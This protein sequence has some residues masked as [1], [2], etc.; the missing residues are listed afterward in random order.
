[1]AE[2]ISGSLILNAISNYPKVSVI[3]LTC[4]GRRYINGLLSSLYDQTYPPDR[5]EIIVIDNGSVDDTV[6]R[7]KEDFP[8]VKLVELGKNLGFARGNNEAL[9]HAGGE[10]LVFMNQD[11]VCHREWIDGLMRGWAEEGRETG[12]TVSNMIL[13]DPAEAESLDRSKRFDEIFYFDLSVFGYGYYRRRKERDV[14]A[15]IFS[16]CSFGIRRDMIEACGGYLFDETFD[17]YAEDTE[18]SLRLFNAGY[19]IRVLRDSVVYHLHSSHKG[20]NSVRAGIAA[21][22]IINRVCAFYKNMSFMEFV[23][24]YPVLIFCGVLKVPHLRVSAWEK[25]LWFLP[26]GLFSPICMLAGIPKLV[27]YRLERKRILAGRKGGPFSL[28]GFIFRR[29]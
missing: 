19:K 3:I 16:A 5:Y 4:N 13:K 28:L 29:I 7:I 25:I 12:V 10:Y 24:Y 1:M 9:K 22:A 2:K 21:K 23:L 20:F 17:M 27:T 14:F 26:F 8:G 18:L 11:L 15:K 6:A